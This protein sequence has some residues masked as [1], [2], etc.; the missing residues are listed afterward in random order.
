MKILNYGSIGNDHVY[1]VHHIVRP[2]E[3]ISTQSF[4]HFPGGKGNNQSIALA[5]AGTKNLFHAG[6]VGADGI[7]LRDNL[8]SLG[9]DTTYLTEVDGKSQ[10]AVIQVDQNAQN[11]IFLFPGASHE[12]SPADV[13]EVLSH[14]SEG[15]ILLIQNEISSVGEMI[16]EAAQRGMKIFFN[17]APMTPEV[18][19]Y[20]LDKITCFVVNETEGQDFTG[21][22]APDD[23]LKAMREMFPQAS[24]VLT[25]GGDGVMYA[26]DSESLSMPAEPGDPVDTTA[27]GD[28]FIGY[29][30]AGLSEGMNAH[31][32]LKLASKASAICVTRPGAGVS[33]PTRDEIN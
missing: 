26:D 5:K 33:I 3:T 24:T 28:T 30:L 21:K 13:K 15:D 14:F 12:T 4:D 20:P 22:T 10:I 17:P 29:Y 11:A 7:W 19:A 6:K 16:E 2:G 9:I 1:K 27:A 31:D 23:I 8:A 32:A 25:L 18:K